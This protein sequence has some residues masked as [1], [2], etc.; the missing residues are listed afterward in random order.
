MIA[1]LI[2]IA[3][4]FKFRLSKNVLFFFTATMFVS[5]FGILHGI[6]KT[7][8]GTI[9]YVTIFLI[10]PFVFVFLISVNPN[11]VLQHYFDKIFPFVYL[12]IAFSILSYLPLISFGDIFNYYNVILGTRI[13]FIS[14]Y[15]EFS[16]P[17]MGWFIFAVPF[18]FFSFI[19]KWVWTKPRLLD[20]FF[21][22]LSLLILLISGR[23][24]MWFSTSLSLFLF[25]LIIVIHQKDVIKKL[26]FVALPIFVFSFFIL[27][28]LNFEFD[29]LV[30]S[31]KI[32]LDTSSDL[33]R[34]TQIKALYNG[35]IESPII[36]QGIG[37]ITLD[38]RHGYWFQPWAYELQ[39]N[40]L[41]FQVGIFGF[42]V[43]V[44]STIYIIYSLL[45]HSLKRRD[46]TLFS[47]TAGF[48]SLILANS[49]NP[50]LNKFD[51]I[52][53]LFFAVHMLNRINGKYYYC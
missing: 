44:L 34:I 49:T 16:S 52:L 13:N 43:Y 1:F 40:L 27:N 47:F 6:L 24:G 51:Y 23:R 37:A 48:S 9:E 19:L 22:F 38:R 4:N 12:V 30:N 31:L 53:I 28:K 3:R 36:G 26:I 29:D 7:A 39:Y 5:F 21:A 33:T 17:L 10:W 46:V 20:L 14:T 41:I 25:I 32:D 18:F 2:L 42:F 50:Y 8:P 45:L 15:P 35:W 11:F